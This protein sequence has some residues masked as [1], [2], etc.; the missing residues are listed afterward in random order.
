MGDRILQGENEIWVDELR[1]EDIRR[2]RALSALVN[3]RTTLA[4][5]G[6]FAVNLERKSGDF[7]DLRGNA[8][9]NTTTRFALDSQINLD[10]FLPV[11]WNTTIPVRFSYNRFSSIPR[12]RR[13][14]DIVLTP[15]QKRNESDVR[16]QTR[17]NISLRKRAA[18]EAP[19]ILSRIFFD[20]INASLNLISDNAVDGA[21]T[22]RRSS[23]NQNLNGTFSYDLSWPQRHSLRPLGWLPTFKSLKEAQFFYL[24]SSL[25]YNVRF[26]RSLRDQ[27][28]FSAVAGDTSDVIDT[29]NENF[30]INESYSVKLTPFRS[31]SA[32]YDLSV[33]RDLR[34]GFALSQFQFGRETSRTQN[35]RVSYNPRVFT[36]LTLSPS[37]TANYRETLETGGQRTPYGNTRRGL[38]VS[39]Q[40]TASARASLNLPA[41]FRPLIKPPKGGQAGGISFL[42]LIGKAGSSL[43][44]VTGNVSRS[45]TFNTFGLR[46]RPSFKYQFGLT[47]TARVEALSVIGGTRTNT[48]VT[49]DQANANSGIRLPG[50][51]SVSSGAT[52]SHSRSFGNANSEDEGVT[53]P[54]VDAS[55]RGL[56]R[57]PIL[58][59]LWSSSNTNFGYQQRHNRRG[60]GGLDDRTIT[61]ETRETSFS[62]LYA[63]TARWK[64]QMSTT[65]RGVR[66]RQNAI[67]YQRNV[68]ADTTTQQPSLQDRLIGT[69]ITE[70]AS[71]SGDLRYSVRGQFQQSLDLNLG[72][73]RSSNQ[74]T[75]QPRSASADTP[76]DLVIRQNTSDWS[77]HL[78]AQYAFS[79][80]FTGGINFRHSRRKD[81]LRDLTNVAWE[82]RFWGDIGFQ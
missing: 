80:S 52:F 31:L 30:T 35:A 40:N 48:R 47:D 14:S 49:R 34:N 46:S 24:P 45:K 26:S 76:V 78:G 3:A 42:R 11:A 15:E 38:T 50:G 41:F 32:D 12:I 20:R 10:K 58:R 73:Q 67:N 69:T 22:R 64:N 1:V 43:Q 72:Y 5:L 37:Y 61:S 70:T 63:W 62:P 17:F 4:D 23:I 79:R 55:W 65:V 21:I 27:K 59:A 36:W 28:S 66:S 9:G 18:Q 81:R 29:R 25:R 44:N 57:L 54:K 60:D 71:L 7:Q 68:A 75:E 16:S 6:N 56:E 19:R 33:N 82:F 13:G 51:F 8:S 39:S 53:F 74:Q 77:V 2:K